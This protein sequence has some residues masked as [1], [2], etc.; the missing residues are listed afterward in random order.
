MNEQQ[1]GRAR[2]T[3]IDWVRGLVMVLMTSDHVSALVYA[4]RWMA[5]GRFM[6]SWSAPI[7]LVPFLNR[8]VSHLCAPTF[9]FLAGTAIAL[10]AARR[11]AHGQGI[12]WDLAIRGLLLIGIE[13]LVFSPRMGA[14]DGFE[15]LLQVLY[16]I[17]VGMLAMAVL[18]RLPGRICGLLGLVIVA[19]HEGVT[20]WLTDGYTT[21]PDLAELLLLDA[22]FQYPQILV[23][24]PALPWLGVM[25]L[26]YWLG[27]RIVAVGQIE[28]RLL[29][30]W[31]AVGFATW[32]VVEWADGYGNCGVLRSDDSWLRWLQVSK[33]PP[34]LGFLGL[35]LGLMAAIL[36]LRC[37][38]EAWRGDALRNRGPLLLLGRTALCYYLLHFGLLGIATLLPP[39]WTTGWIGPEREREAS[40]AQVWLGVL[41]IVVVLLPVCALF[42]RLK[43]A[44]PRSPLRW[45]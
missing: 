6:S 42:E 44:F 21:P 4:D 23:V 5:D 35:E 29:W 1:T 41:A 12:A 34:S 13:L 22:G 36:A 45:I 16:A 14:L 27:C 8:W 7:P 20:R 40:L 24:Y 28:E 43:R 18:H 31:S 10:S 38:Y 11:R 37:R 3:A 30:S 15:Q 19:G 33:Y 9:V 25:L 32:L 2:L 39:E 26:G 17:G